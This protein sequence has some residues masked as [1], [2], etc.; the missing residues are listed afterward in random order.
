MSANPEGSGFAMR[1]L[2]AFARLDDTIEKR[3]FTSA[4]ESYVASLLNADADKVLKKVAEESAEFILASMALS[5]TLG[6]SCP[7]PEGS[8]EEIN[9]RQQCQT[10]KERIVSEAADLQ[11]HLQVALAHYNLSIVDVARE[12]ARREGTSGLV[13]KARR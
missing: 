6:N 4:N 2:S 5:T 3:R 8:A 1:D 7:L 11:F 9:L 13:E 12:L 10:M